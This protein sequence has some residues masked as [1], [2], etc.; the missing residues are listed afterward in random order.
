M[1]KIAITLLS[2]LFLNEYNAQTDKN[3]VYTSV[4]QVAEF[5]GGMEELAKYVSSNLN[6]PISAKENGV[7]GKTFLKFIIT[8]KGEIENAEVLQEMQNCKEC[9]AEALRV[10]KAMPLWSPAKVKE[11]PVKSYC[12]IPIKFM[13]KKN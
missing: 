10:I 6:Y 4:D 5:K 13:P 2:L 12:V 7:E 3:G 11:K 8:E 1:K 9:D